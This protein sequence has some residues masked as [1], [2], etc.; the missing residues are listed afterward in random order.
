MIADDNFP[1]QLS[2]KYID[3]CDCFMIS[4]MIMACQRAVVAIKLNRSSI[5]KESVQRIL[6][7]L[8]A[9]IKFLRT[10]SELVRG[11]NI[12]AIMNAENIAGNIISSESFKKR[13]LGLDRQ[14]LQMAYKTLLSDA[15]EAVARLM[16]TR[17][18]GKKSDQTEELTRISALLVD[19]HNFFW[20]AHMQQTQ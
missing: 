15:E 1:D 9:F 16:S 10:E 20:S 17:R 3:S 18:V 5:H 2:G 11:N 19:L 8:K 7:K 4:V 6:L 14:Q 12:Y 13:Y